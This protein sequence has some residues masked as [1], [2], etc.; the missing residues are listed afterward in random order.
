MAQDDISI[1][2][3]QIERTLSQEQSADATGHKQRYKTKRKEH[4][5][6]ETNAA[7]P[8]GSQP[9][10]CLNSRRHTDRQ[11]NNRERHGGVRTHAADE[12]VMAP[13]KEAQ[14]TDGKDGKDHRAIPKDW[15]AR[16]CGQ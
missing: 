15:F 11:S 7:T 14:E 2:Q 6:S 4:W 12:H 9:I 1:V 10:E 3:R 5:R 8:K 16:K 13:H